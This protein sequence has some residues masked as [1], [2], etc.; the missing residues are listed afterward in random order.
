M[1]R[2]ITGLTVKENR[3]LSPIHISPTAHA[4]GQK[5]IWVGLARNIL[6]KSFLACTFPFEDRLVG[7]NIRVHL[8]YASNLV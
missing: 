3:L 8:P 1:I 5:S 7:D 6:S 2:V 4:I